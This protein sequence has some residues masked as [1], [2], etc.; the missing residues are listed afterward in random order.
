[1]SCCCCTEKLFILRQHTIWR[2]FCYKQK[3]NMKKQS[4][5]NNLLI[6]LIF[7]FF[8][9]Y[10]KRSCL[11]EL[12]GVSRYP[13]TKLLPV[14]GNKTLCDPFQLIWHEYFCHD[15]IIKVTLRFQT[16]RRCCSI[17]GLLKGI[18]YFQ[19]WVVQ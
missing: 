19:E 18:V 1:M 8:S 3:I 7:L 16:K 17:W 2:V 12:Q 5:N 13:G 9:F 11:C 10:Q 6:F 4:D 14:N 15:F